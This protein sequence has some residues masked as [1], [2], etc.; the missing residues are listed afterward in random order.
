MDLNLVNFIWAVLALPLGW[1]YASWKDQKKEIAELKT[2]VSNLE[3]DISDL[4]L[5]IN[6]LSEDVKIL[7]A[8]ITQVNL[9]MERRLY[10][11][12]IESLQQQIRKE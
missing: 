4:K 2:R 7:T 10:T 12:T 3:K 6:P 8:T 1:L 5:K 9:D 11:A